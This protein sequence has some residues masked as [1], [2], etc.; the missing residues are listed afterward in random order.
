MKNLIILTM[1]LVISAF[2]A[3][4]DGNTEVVV[5]LGDSTT[6][7]NLNTPGA[8]LTDYVEAH[9]T[10][11]HLQTRIVNSGIGSATAKIGLG[12]LQA[13]VLVHDPAVVTISFGLNDTGKSTPDEYRECL[14]KIVQ[15]VQKNTHAKILL[16]TSTPFINERHQ[17]RQQFSDKGGMDAVLDTNFCS[18]MRTLG[19]KH[20]IPVCDLHSHFTAL[21][22]KNPKLRDELIL[23][24]G[25]H[26][27]DKGNEVAAQHLAP[28]IATLLTKPTNH[29][30]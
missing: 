3:H 24:D 27:T 17:W 5:M 20:N 18:A 30:Q 19:K 25:V 8:K 11:E 7:C 6:V 12:E 9:L 10:K 26:L 28:Y 14:E 22:G 23:P 15:S 29:S 4:A 2:T 1:V 21:F 16:I 13:R